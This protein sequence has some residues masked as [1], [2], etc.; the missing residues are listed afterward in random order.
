LL[1]AALKALDFPP[2]FLHTVVFAPPSILGLG[3]PNMWNDQGIDHI[4]AILKH[5]DSPN[6]N[7]TGC[8]QRDEMARLRLELG[9]PGNAT[10]YEYKKLHLCTT[11][12]WFHITWQFCNNH[13]LTL[14]DTLPDLPLTR[15]QDQYIMLAFLLHGYSAKNLHHMLNV[16]RLWVRAITLTDITT[17]DG[18]FLQKQCQDRTYRRPPLEYEWPK[19]MQPN[20]HCWKLW[21]S[22]IATCFLRPD[23][24]HKKLRNPLG[25]WTKLPSDWDWFYSPLQVFKTDSLNGSHHKSG[26]LGNEIKAINQHASKDSD[27]PSLQPTSYLRMYPRQQS[28]ATVPKSYDIKA[29]KPSNLMKTIPPKSAGGTNQSILWTTSNYYCRDSPMAHPSV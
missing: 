17:G 10:N 5:G 11:K 28:S 4:T 12:V 20:A 22:A 1:K 7:I 18:H 29:P 16:C 26:T 6:R 25:K 3:V 9:L 19:T 2:T 27:E 23:D 24:P 14:Q 21:L 15:R 13:H 8:L